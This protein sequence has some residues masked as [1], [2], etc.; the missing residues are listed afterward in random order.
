MNSVRCVIF[1]A[2]LILCSGPFS[3][4]AHLTFEEKRNEDF[5]R[6]LNCHE[7]IERLDENHA[8]P[9]DQCHILPE[10][11]KQYLTNHDLIVRHPAAFPHAD[12]LCGK[13]H[14]KE[15]SNLKNSLHYTLAG[16]INQTRYLWGAQLHPTPQ[17]S[18]FPHGILEALPPNS[19]IVQS[20]ADLVD[21]LLRRRCLSCHP[22]VVPPQKRGLYR[23]LGCAACHVFYDDDGTY[24]GGDRILFGKQGYAKTHRFCKP[25]PVEQCLHCHNGPRV[26]ADY[27]GFFEHDFHQSYRT[28]IREG[29]VP[30]QVYLMDYHR[31]R[32]DVHFKLGMLCVDCHHIGDV[33][34]EGP[35]LD[36]QQE[37]V[38]ARCQH[39]HEAF[40]KNSNDQAHQDIRDGHFLSRQ[41]RWHRLPNY[42]GTVVAHSIPQMKKVHCIGCHGAWGF[43]DF[44]FSLLRDDR[45]DL[46][47]W[48]PWR[49]QGEASITDLFDDSGRFLG[50]TPG[51]GPWFLGWRFRRWEYLI[52]GID[53]KNRIVPIRPRYQYLVS[54]VDKTGKVILD[55]VIP[56]RGDGSGP[57]WAYM[58]FYPH[59]VQRR[60]RS[61]E[62][63][64]GQ[65]L[66]AGHGLWQGHGPDLLLTRPCPPVYN[67]LRLLSEEEKKRLLEKTPEY[68]KWRFRTL[69]QDLND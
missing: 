9:C 5:S 44:G 57:G 24:R 6:C 19:S 63:C 61:C 42:D 17:Y 35:I 15:I 45:K 49:L 2:F 50:S 8:F 64:H 29:N 43:G 27:A 69:L 7:G 30:E 26:G 55:S 3:W 23:G 54:F 65:P 11:R 21:D 36:S 22:E 47:Q 20:P 12:V 51:P 38:G 28:P 1:I 52:L 14:L 31:L 66:A 32:R 48:A 16:L 33:M 62:A 46:S 10:N 18:A 68:R 67:P 34:G 4:S 25:I 56:A 41:G 60:G 58:P 39:C 53:A 37:A 13:C 59:T 40:N